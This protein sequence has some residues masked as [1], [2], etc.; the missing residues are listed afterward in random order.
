MNIEREHHV[1][2]LALGL[3]LT[4]WGVLVFVQN[5]YFT[6]LALGLSPPNWSTWVA[7]ISFLWIDVIDTIAAVVFVTLIVLGWA[8]SRHRRRPRGTRGGAAVTGL[9]V[10]GLLL[11]VGFVLSTV[12]HVTLAQIWCALPAFPGKGC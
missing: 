11:I 3:G 8:W 9:V 7:G 1:I 4:A 12:F 6:A 10:L 2:L 5:A